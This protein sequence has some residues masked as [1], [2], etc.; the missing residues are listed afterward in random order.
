VLDKYQADKSAN[1]TGAFNTAESTLAELEKRATSAKDKEAYALA[2][3]QLYDQANKSNAAIK[4][5]KQAESDY[6][7]ASTA[8]RLAA[9][10]QLTGDKSNAIKYYQLAVSRSPKT[11]PTARSAY[12]DYRLELQSLEAQ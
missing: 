4:K 10:Y 3:I 9:E 1:P 2:L 12:N 5:A 6:H 7:S 11:A 8:A